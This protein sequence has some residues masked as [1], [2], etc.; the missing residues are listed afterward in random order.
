MIP[1]E[2]AHPGTSSSRDHAIGNSRRVY[3]AGNY[4]P[5]YE[6]NFGIDHSRIVD[7]LQVFDISCTIDVW[8]IG[9]KWRWI[10]PA[11]SIDPNSGE[12]GGAMSL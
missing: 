1:R 10:P 3:T 9:N 8:A 2:E 12:G 6:S 11:A 5:E 4:Y 7:L